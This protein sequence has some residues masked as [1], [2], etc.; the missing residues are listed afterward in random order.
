ME[1]DDGTVKET[2]AIG[3]WGKLFVEY[4]RRCGRPFTT[5]TSGLEKKA[6][7][8]AGFVDIKEKEI[9]VSTNPLSS[10]A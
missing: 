9:K 1:S 3:Q 5:V 8:E 2:D 6:M 4:G 7:E 10:P